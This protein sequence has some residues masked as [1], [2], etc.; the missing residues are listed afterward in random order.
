MKNKH[1]CILQTF[2][3]LVFKVVIEIFKESKQIGKPLSKSQTTIKDTRKHLATK[4]WNWFQ[5]IK[6]FLVNVLRL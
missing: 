5:S 6:G 3:Y 4:V 1:L 2:L